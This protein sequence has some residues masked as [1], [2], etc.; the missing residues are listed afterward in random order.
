[1][2][3]K[4]L[5]GFACAL[6]VAAPAVLAQ[7]TVRCETGE[8]AFS[9]NAIVSLSHQLSDANCVEG[10][11]WGVRGNLIWVK[12]GC[13]ADFM[14]TPRDTVNNTAAA[15]GMTLQCGSDGGRKICFADTHYG[16]QLT[17]QL[18]RSGCIEGKSW[19][20]DNKGIWVDKGCR[21]EFVLAGPAYSSV[22][23]TTTQAVVC[24]SVNNTRHHCATDTK[25]GVQLTNQLSKNNCVFNQSWGYDDKGIW[26]D[27]GCRAEFSV[28]R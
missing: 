24:E 13:R 18:S 8:C 15:E 7:T 11:T 9:G 16:V 26:V 22:G 1:L 14:I 2:R 25:F 21:A 28:G 27:K 4:L 3:Q 23:R 5:F 20:F 6:L 17:K 12:S 10:K 19:G